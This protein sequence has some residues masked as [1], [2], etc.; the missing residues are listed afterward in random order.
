MVYKCLTDRKPVTPLTHEIKVDRHTN[1]RMVVKID[2]H[3]C[4]SPQDMCG[5]CHMQCS[6]RFI[7]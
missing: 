2:L 4:L 6:D 1:H 7:F 3:R 5:T